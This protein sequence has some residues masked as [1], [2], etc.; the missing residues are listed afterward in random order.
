MIYEFCA[1]NVTLLEK[2]MKA[3]ARRVELCDNLAV[4]GTTP[5]FGVIKAGVELGEIYDTTMMTMI[6]PRGGDFVYSSLEVEIMIEDISRAREAG[7]QGVVF[8][9]L[10]PDN[11]LDTETLERLLEASKGLEIVFHMAFDSIP[12]EHQ[13]A[14]IDWL[15][16]HGVRRI[17]TR[18]GDTNTPLEVRFARY[19]DFLNYAEGRIE[20]LPGGGI[21]MS[22]REIFLDALGVNQLHGTKVVF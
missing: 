13:L 11:E 12:E 20:I 9:A 14:A 16:S 10:T 17:L 4:G 1:E 19:R 22:N 7:S 15:A 2:A 6:R 5:S 18:A 21:D 8:G 3:G